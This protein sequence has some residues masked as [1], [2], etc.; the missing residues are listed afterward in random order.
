MACRGQAIR[1]GAAPG[2]VG[3]LKGHARYWL[4]CT[5]FAGGK[6]LNQVDDALE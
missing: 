6:P 1:T 4:T 2:R 3:R 5:T